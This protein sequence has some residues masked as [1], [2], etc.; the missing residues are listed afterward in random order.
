MNNPRPGLNSTAEYTTS[1]LPWLT[2]SIVSVTP[3]RIDFHKVTRALTIRNLTGPGDLNVGFTAV[4]VS[5][6]N[7]FSIPVGDSERFEFR[8]KVLWLQS[9]AG[10]VSYSLAAELTLID[11][12]QM[13]LL[14]GSTTHDNDPGSGWNN[15][16]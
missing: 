8:T 3:Q 2:S 4:G 15:I 5:G 16:G 13:P 9:S 12:S 1:G 14:T 11:A 7:K 10:T 6:S